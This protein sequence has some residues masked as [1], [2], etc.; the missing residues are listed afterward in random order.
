MSDF[1]DISRS[2]GSDV[3]DSGSGPG[4]TGIA[5]SPDW[6]IFHISSNSALGPLLAGRGLAA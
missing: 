4:H 2:P 6:C 1:L 3:D 5:I